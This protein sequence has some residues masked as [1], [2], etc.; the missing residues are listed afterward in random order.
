M[1]KDLVVRNRSYRRFDGAAP[2]D[3]E[4]L[5]SLVE[6]ARLT[7][8]ASNRQCL[9]FF[10]SAGEK[11]NEVFECLKWAGHLT[12]WDGP[13]EGERPSAYIVVLNDTSI[14]KCMDA[15]VGIACQTIL[16]GAVEQG[17]GGC[18]FGAVDHARLS[19]LL[20]LP[21]HM[22]ITLVIAIGR[23]VE[24]VVLEDMGPEGDF[25]YWRD[26][27]RVHHVP[28]RSL[29]EIVFNEVTIHE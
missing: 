24:T 12:D 29:R 7:P 16:L 1:F 17:L 18:M 6:L 3:R 14:G 26:E 10:L 27:N 9:K 23:P 19:H 25:K 15:D 5:L 2:V 21:D 11:N 20:S 22:K 4:T 28:K 13:E 8:S